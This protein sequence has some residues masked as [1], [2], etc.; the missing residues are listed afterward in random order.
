MISQ[1]KVYIEVKLTTTNGCVI[2]YMMCAIKYILPLVVAS[3][4]FITVPRVHAGEPDN[5]LYLGYKAVHDGSFEKAIG[6]LKSAEKDEPLLSDYSL[7]YLGEAYLALNRFDE[8]L[9]AFIG[10]ITHSGATKSPLEPS[11]Q[12]K[13]GDIYLSKGDAEN[14]INIYKV[15]LTG[16]SDNIQ[17]PRIL[18]KLIPL[19][20]QGNRQEEAYPFIKRLL[21]EF[22]QADYSDDPL[23][24]QV[25]SGELGK[26][27]IDEFSMRAKGL[28]K[29]KS[30]TKVV[31]ESK[32]YLLK[33][34][35]WFPYGAPLKHNDKV[36]FLLG[37]AFY[38]AK[39]YK[40]AVNI[41]KEL[42]PIADDSKIRQ[43]SLIYLAKAYIK[44]KDFKSARDVLKTFISIYNDRGLRDEALYKLAMIAKD[45]GDINLAAAFL[46]QLI[47]ENPS[48]SYKNDALWQ[49]SWI[50]YQQGNLKESLEAL[51]PLEN[52]PLK[53]RA[54]YWQGKI[55]LVLGKKD[56]AARLFKI[57]AD[58]FPPVYYSAKS[59]KA[60]E[61]I[62]G[63]EEQKLNFKIEKNENPK[64]YESLP[65]QRT[66]RLLGL[67][68]NNLALTELA[69]MNHTIDPISIS[70][71][72]RQAGDFYNSYILA[73]S[74]S[75]ASTDLAYQLAFPE[76][77]KE[78]VERSAN[79]F[80]IDPLLVYAVM[81]QESE[82]NE[83]AVSVSGAVGLMQIMPGT[84]EMIA[85][86]LSYPLFKEDK[87]F[88]PAININFGSWYL[89]TMITRFNGS[90]PLAVAAY[91]A[92][93]N[94]VDGWLKKWGRLDMDEFIENIPYQETRKYVERVIGYYE[95]YKAIYRYGSEA[96]LAGRIAKNGG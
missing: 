66:H 58:R 17:T 92:G 83:K 96:N 95:A 38:Q 7:Y 80:H 28:L 50:S 14:S 71:L 77:Y 19:L 57:A 27:N 89:K 79:E 60:L 65:L 42:F 33:S 1:G 4:I 8:A 37:Q 11:A 43:E 18:N 52:S 87:L 44:L 85:K 63:Q 54:V 26:L 6:H 25:L 91:N 81:M 68:L 67:G 13:I 74:L 31:E 78:L 82:F 20:L 21:T 70:L 93:P 41:F 90:L 40:K 51:I 94:S 75:Y 56:N 35:T 15:L 64:P 61:M 86:K 2:F 39:N 5:N 34:P 72:Y 73:R 55:S 84:G 48:S 69:S 22:P 29:A 59:R 10:S 12:E 45:E 49:I 3:C 47:A 88:L 16:Y 30:Y 62:S 36:G 23:T 24:S 32:A 53:M 9:N 46:N 76:G